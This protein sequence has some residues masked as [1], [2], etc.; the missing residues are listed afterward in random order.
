[1]NNSNIVLPIQK[2]VMGNID[3][4]KHFAHEAIKHSTRPNHT[5]AHIWTRFLIS[6][7]LETATKHGGSHHV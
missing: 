5:L 3:S 6:S 2:P 4:C 1:M 7:F